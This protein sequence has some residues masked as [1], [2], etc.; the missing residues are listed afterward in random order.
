M[1]KEAN[2][3]PFFG[4]VGGEGSSITNWLRRRGKKQTGETATHDFRWEILRLPG[5]DWGILGKKNGGLMAGIS[6]IWST[7]RKINKERKNWRFGRCFF[8]C[9]WMIFN[10]F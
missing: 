1:I 7:P 2:L 5:P 10:D 6:C 8:F 3:D 9:K 4:G